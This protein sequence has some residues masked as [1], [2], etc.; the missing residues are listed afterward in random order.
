MYTVYTIFI[1][2]RRSKH[3]F[4]DE[5]SAVLKAFQL[6]ADTNLSTEVIGEVFDNNDELVHTIYV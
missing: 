6:E 5:V 2:G 3:E 4:N 1:E